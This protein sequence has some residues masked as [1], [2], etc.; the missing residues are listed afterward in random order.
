MADG[1]ARVTGKPA[2]CLIISGPGMTNIA[3]AMGAAYADSVPMLVISSVNRTTDLAMGE[4]RL[5][6]LNSQRNLIAGVAAFSHTLMRPDELP[7][8][9]ARAF[10]I[11]TSARPRPVHIE[12]PLDVIGM[13]ADHVPVEVSSPPNRPLPTP[14]VIESAAQMIVGATRP[15]VFV[16]GGASD[17]VKEL[18]V[19][20]NL[21]QAPVAATVNARGTLPIDHPTRFGTYFPL[22]FVE[23]FV[24]Q[25]DLI[26]AIGTELGEPDYCNLFNSPLTANSKL[27]RIDIDLEQL[28]RTRKTDIG[29]YGDARLALQLLNAKL[30][31]MEPPLRISESWMRQLQD[32]QTKTE[33]FISAHPAM[34]IHRRMFS[35]INSVTEAPIIF[36]D[37]TQPIFSANLFYE[38]PT[39][40][41]YYN[42]GTGFCTLGYALPAA[43]GAKLACPHR[44]V[45]C[46]IGDGG[47]MFT[48]PELAVAVEQQTAVTVLLWNNHGY[49]EIK[50]LMLG[51]EVQPVGVDLHTPDFGKVMEGF[52]CHYIKVQQMS[53]CRRA[54]QEAA[55]LDGPVLVEFD[56]NALLLETEGDSQ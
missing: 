16:G 47:L 21:M 48:L 26:I 18:E 52:G 17:A 22:A 4:A 6:E 27:I 5:H 33:R 8:L 39:P 37:N 42:S 25:A 30:S 41:S 54:L 45:F 43:I 44:P 2:A 32:V 51:A 28:T 46:V 53:Q 31:D 55:G 15:I 14:D 50:K 7:R 11:F 9:L 38:A 10:A 40:R 35:I 49:S 19:L 34:V 29:V 12:I 56:E 1:Y 3:T 13:P 20:L 23:D 36:G 24:A